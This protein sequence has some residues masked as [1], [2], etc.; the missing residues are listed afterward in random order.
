[1]NFYDYYNKSNNPHFTGKGFDPEET[2]AQRH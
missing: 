2:L 1:M